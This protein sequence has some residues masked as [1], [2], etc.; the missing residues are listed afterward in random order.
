MVKNYRTV[1]PL[2]FCALRFLIQWL[3]REHALFRAI[4]SN[5]T[6]QDIR[7]ALTY[8]Q[9]ARTFEGLS[10]DPS[11]LSSIRLAL[12]DIRKR[13]SLAPVQMVVELACKL[14]IEFKQFNVS[15]AS[16]LLWLSVREPVVVYDK[17][18]VSALSGH[19]KHKF[20]A[21]N[22]NE[23]ASV[24]REEYL[25]HEPDIAAATRQLPKGRRFMPNCA[26]TDSELL[27]LAEQSWFKER[28]FDIFLWEIGGDG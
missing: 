10:K 23:Y 24:W 11:K 13:R 17:R 18:A 9:V 25:N 4:S 2:T 12:R 15:A 28:V 27:S 1:F 14:Q 6:D 26:L 20:S 3:R 22:Y 7:E 21:R 19:F 8:F 5:P 16:K